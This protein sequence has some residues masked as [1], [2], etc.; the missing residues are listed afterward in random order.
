MRAALA[1]EILGQILREGPHVLFK[2]GTLLQGRFGWP[3]PRAS[4]AV[5]LEAR[6]PDD[7]R[8]A[9]DAVVDRFSSSGLEVADVETVVEPVRGFEA[10]RGL[11]E[12]WGLPRAP[13]LS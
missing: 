13:R 7:V 5:D 8:V 4:V 6:E 10:V 12:A 3:P 2:G 11:R 9:L 1:M